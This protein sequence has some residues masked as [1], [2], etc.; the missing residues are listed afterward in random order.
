LQGFSFCL[1]Y[2]YK[3]THTDVEAAVRESSDSK[4]RQDSAG[5]VGRELSGEQE[6]SGSE[7]SREGEERSMRLEDLMS[8]RSLSPR[9]HRDR[10]MS[11]IMVASCREVN[12]H[13]ALA[14]DLRALI[15][16]SAARTILRQAILPARAS[17]DC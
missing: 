15:K 13:K 2:Y 10:S 17:L 6:E 9:E 1:L 4:E 5:G 16:Q 7:G 8:S 3:S 11:A 14:S 12:R